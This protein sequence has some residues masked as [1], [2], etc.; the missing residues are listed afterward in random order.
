MPRGPLRG[1]ARFFLLCRALRAPGRVSGLPA[2]IP[3]TM[4]LVE[5]VAPAK[6]NLVLDVAGRRGDGYHEV[7]SVI[8]AL[9]LSDTVIVERP[10]DACGGN[11]RPLLEVECLPGLAAA[12][13]PQGD[14]NLAVR[15]LRALERHVGKRCPVRLRLI[16]RIPVAAG[17]GG[18]S[19]DAAAV[20][21]GVNVLLNLGL[22]RAELAGVA[23]EVGSDVPFFLVGGTALAAGRG[24]AV[25]PLPFPGRWP[26]VLVKPPF[27]VATAEVYRLWDEAAAVSHPDVEA[28]ERAVAAGDFAGVC[29]ALGN[30]LEPV[31]A[32]LRAEVA[33]VAERLRRAGASGVLMSGSGPTVFALV[34]DR[35]EAERV[36]RAA[37][38]GMEAVVV[39]EFSPEGVRVVRQG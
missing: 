2:R 32:S 24:E 33:A 25:R 22:D 26:V 7:R 5:V 17:L 13:L 37:G 21:W 29:A 36:A 34:R 30:A 39:T 20:L 35:G 27:A 4:R 18:G 15:A 16:K 10:G 19:S 11:G 1:R 31:T 23:A 3:F 38:E 14:D 8:Q 28:M 6:I 9:A 12:A